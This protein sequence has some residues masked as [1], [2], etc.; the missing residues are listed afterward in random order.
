MNTNN[1]VG[2]VVG[3]TNS[4]NLYDVEKSSDAMPWLMP[5]VGFQGGDLKS[6]IEIG[7]RN[8]LSLIN[9]SRGIIYNQ[10]GTIGDIREAAENY[11]K[12]IRNFL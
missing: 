11:T 7:E 12:K 5:G 3:A 1:N 6:S 2:I 8:F 4:N 10:N 9:V